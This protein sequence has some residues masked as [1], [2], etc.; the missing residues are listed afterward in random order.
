MA[1][2]EISSVG[3]RVRVAF[4]TTPGVRPT[5]GYC[6]VPKVQNAPEQDMGVDTIDASSISDYVKVYIDGQQD[7]GGDQQF[8]LI[9]S[10]ETIDFWDKLASDAITK[11][12]AG[13]RLWW[14][15]WFPNTKKSYFYAGK[16][17]SLGTSGININELDT[18]PAHVVFKQHEGWK[19]HSGVAVDKNYIVVGVGESAVFNIYSYS[20][21]PTAVSTT[22]ATATATKGSEIKDPGGTA[23]IPVTVAGVATGT[24]IITI[25]DGADSF[26]IDVV[27]E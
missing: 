10:D 7:P 17:K 25:T 24:T 26:T 6:D 21:T 20:G 4:E 12:A 27:V 11:E 23:Y 16:P 3:A 1:N 22:P 19:A 13:K 8:N 15:Y 14:E 5:F 9:H 18:I 2:I